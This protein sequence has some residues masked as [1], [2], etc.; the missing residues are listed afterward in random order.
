MYIE[1]IDIENGGIYP[2]ILQVIARNPENI[3]TAIKDSISEVSAYLM[4]RYDIDTELAKTGSSRNNLVLKMIRDIAVY[5]CFLQS[6]QVNMPE[7]RINNYKST[8]AMLKEVQAERASIPGLTRLS[9]IDGT[10]GSSY[11]RFGG[12]TKRNNN[13]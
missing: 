3:A 13:Y 1:Q 6:N 7:I 10:S 12:N 5:N 8:I 9:D 2:E 4:A 11:L